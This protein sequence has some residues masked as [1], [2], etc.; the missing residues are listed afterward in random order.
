MEILEEWK[1]NVGFK[2]FGFLVYLDFHD[3]IDTLTVEQGIDLGIELD[4]MM[5]V[6]SFVL[7]YGNAHRKG[8]WDKDAP[9]AACVA[10]MDG[11]IFTDER[12]GY[13]GYIDIYR[14]SWF[15]PNTIAVRGSK[16]QIARAL[17]RPAL[18][19]DDKEENVA[20]FEAAGLF[21]TGVVVKRGKKNKHR[22]IKGFHYEAS[23]CKWM[24]DICRWAKHH[25]CLSVDELVSVHSKNGPA[26]P[27]KNERQF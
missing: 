17:N 18:L 22:R 2:H 11:V 27:G 23:P 25:G 19:F 20:W 5:H 16:A 10:E 14:E 8:I 9:W 4:H 13:D 21:H 6:G 15:P 7:S 3:V 1:E 26:G 24:E 12:L